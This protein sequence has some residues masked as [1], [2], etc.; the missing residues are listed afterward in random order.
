MASK[1]TESSL[2][3]YEQYVESMFGKKSGIIIED[4]ENIVLEKFSTGSLSF[5]RDMKSGYAKGTMIE[6]FGDSGTGKTT[7][8]IHAVAEHQLKYPGE[9]ILWID[10]EKVFDPVYFRQIGIDISPDRFKLARPDTGEDAWELIINFAKIMKN[11]MIVL[12]SA[13]LLLPAKEEE[14]Q[15]GDAQMGSAARMNSQGLRK[16]FP[17]MGFEK[18]TFFVINQIRS[19]IGGYGDPTVTTGGKAWEFYARTRIQTYAQK[20]EAGEYSNHKF[21]QVKSNYGH[22]DRVTE[23]T[24]EYG[25]GVNRTKELLN[26]AVEYDIVKRGGSWFSYGETKLGQGADNVVDILDDNL[27]LQ[28]ELIQKLKDLKILA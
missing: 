18:T 21:K 26:L 12:D 4:P 28:S 3:A 10:L 23:T 27:E 17:H 2:K 16:L 11:G 19:K 13:S 6:V 20:G 24:I 15:V 22:K 1:E 25:V 5:D 7:L 9:P 14:G 8:A